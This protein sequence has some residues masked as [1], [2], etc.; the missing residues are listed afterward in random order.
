MKSRYIL[1]I[2]VLGLGIQCDDEV[3]N[4]EFYKPS[5]SWLIIKRVVYRLEM[6]YFSRFQHGL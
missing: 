1:L 5:K 2:L 6:N 4:Q 3:K